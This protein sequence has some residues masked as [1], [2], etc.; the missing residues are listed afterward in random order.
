MPSFILFTGVLLAWHLP[1]L[2]DATLRSNTLH[3][4]EHTL[5]FATALMFWKQVIP[6][7]PLRARLDVPQRL[8]Y[9]VG[10]MVATW[11]LA[12]VLA[13]APHPL[14]SV[15]AQSSAVPAASRRWP[16]NSSRR[17]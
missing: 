9:I 4:L 2:F 7:P 12:V 5:F 10:A 16:I 13:F 11:I 14:Y 8:F 15:Y 6:S 3:A 1:V 17:A